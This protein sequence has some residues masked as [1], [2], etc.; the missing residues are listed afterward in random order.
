MLERA[1]AVSMD[2]LEVGKAEYMRAVELLRALNA[3]REL[4]VATHDLGLLAMQR[5]DYASS[6]EL[7]QESIQLARENLDVGT[8]A[9]ATGTLG[10]IELGEGQF[11][12]AKELLLEALELERGIDHLNLGSANNLVGLAAIAASHKDFENACF[13][14]GAYDAHRELIGASH[15]T[16]IRDLLERVLAQVSQHLGGEEIEK[17]KARGAELSLAEAVDRTLA[18]RSAGSVT[19]GARSW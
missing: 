15:E 13:F 8:E 1:V 16:F 14:V 6:H 19:V 4:A 5:G 18:E 12:R 7:I 3:T 9:N 17:A 2:D 10:F 11:D